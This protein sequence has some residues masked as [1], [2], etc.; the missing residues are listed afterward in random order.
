VANLVVRRP[1]HP[2]SH[3][4]LGD[5]SGIVDI[6]RNDGLAVL[7]TETG[8]VIAGRAR[9]PRATGKVR[10]AK[11]RGQIKTFHV[12]CASNEMIYGIGGPNRKARRIID[13]LMPGPPLV[14]V[15]A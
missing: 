2:F 5:V 11:G 12:A 14:V 15:R 3:L 1:R 4:S 13:R 6:L 8:Y 9:S 7:P 10:A